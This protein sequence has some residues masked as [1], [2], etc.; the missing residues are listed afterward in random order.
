MKKIL[1]ATGL[2]LCVLFVLLRCTVQ[3]KTEKNTLPPQKEHAALAVLWQQQ[4]AEYRALCYQ[5]YNLASERI[6]QLPPK[7]EQPY[8]IVTDIDETVLDNSPYN[9]MQVLEDKAFSKDDWLAWGQQEAAKPLP[10][11]QAFFQLADSLGIAT[12]YISNRYEAQLGATINNLK[13]LNFPNADSNHVFLKTA[14]SEK[15]ARRDR[16]LENY[17]V[18]LYLGDNLSD[19]SAQFDKQNSETRNALVNQM[20]SR[21]GKGFIVF[22]QPDVWRLGI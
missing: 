18:V 9:G 16:V 19:F 8:A 10:G 15:Q 1:L 14:T 11:S 3:P 7:G 5:A 20:H 13:A 12:F 22:P 17:E 4:A 21:F 6:Q 2:P